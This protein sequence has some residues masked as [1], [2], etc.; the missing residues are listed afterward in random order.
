MIFK[1]ICYRNSMFISIGDRIEIKF[2]GRY[3]N[4][5]ILFSGV[6]FYLLLRW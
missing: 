2:I 5:N 3:G 4:I 1:N 6:D